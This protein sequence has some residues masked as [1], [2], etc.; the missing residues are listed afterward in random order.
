M[1]AINK[2]KTLILKLFLQ[3]FKYIFYNELL[4]QHLVRARQQWVI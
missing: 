4:L 3:N 2:S 1:S